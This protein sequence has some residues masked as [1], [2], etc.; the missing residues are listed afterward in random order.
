MCQCKSV[1]EGIRIILSYGL[2]MVGRRVIYIWI[3][4][5]VCFII[6]EVLVTRLVDDYILGPLSSWLLGDEADVESAEGA[7]SGRDGGVS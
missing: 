5:T 1:Y 6:M 7:E 3:L 4:H 2:R